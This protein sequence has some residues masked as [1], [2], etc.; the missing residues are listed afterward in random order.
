MTVSVRLLLIGAP[1]SEFRLAA[2]MA[3]DAG[4]HVTM[5]DG[6]ADALPV[7]RTRGAHLVLVDVEADVAGFLADLRAERILSPV[8]ACGIDAPAERAVAAIRAGARDY[9]P[10]PPDRTLIAAV[11]LTAAAEVRVALIGEDPA[12]LRATSYAFAM[13]KARAPMVIGGER[14][15]GKEAVARAIHQASG[16][17]GRFVVVECAGVAADV[18][19][20]EIFGHD[21]GAF[22]GAVARRL[23]AI[24]R[25]A[26]GT[27]LFR[28]MDCL[29][30]ALQA[31]LFEVLRDEA[32]RRLGGSEA[33][34]VTARFL[35]SSSVDLPRRVR[36]GQFR[37][38]LLTRL[39]LVQVVLPPLRDRPRDVAPLARHLAQRHAA[40]NVLPDRPV[41]DSAIA[42]LQGYGWPGNVAEL[43]ATLHRAVLLAKGETI[44]PDDLVSL[45]GTRL[46]SR[47]A[48]AP[49]LE[50]GD[51]VGRTV[52]EVERELI[53]Q[54]LERCH[55]NRTSA[56]TILGISVR[57]MRNKLRTFI[58][59]GISVSPAA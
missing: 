13:A 46:D 35:T 53:L 21:A 11:I 58:E 47:A 50:V 40:A 9:L 41:T 49:A 56:S 33:V 43:D 12:F 39:S 17:S 3:R 6:P 34:P 22:D 15:S 36:D 45:D 48:G 55:G 42:L 28:D 44:E 4:A 14:G 24:E 29:P 51:L 38:D 23:G 37:A 16:R 1:G 26:H 30:A 52:E 59:S 31:R 25:A 5:V 7:M 54:T 8:I 19:E 18:L 57:T 32:L 20:S 2:R 27:V 10:L